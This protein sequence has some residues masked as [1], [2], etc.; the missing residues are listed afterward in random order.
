V[1]ALEGRGDYSSKNWFLLIGDSSPAGNITA[2]KWVVPSGAPMPLRA[3][4]ANTTIRIEIA[5]VYSDEHAA[6][7]TQVILQIFSIVDGKAVEAGSWASGDWHYEITTAA[8]KATYDYTFLDNVRPFYRAIGRD[9]KPGSEIFFVIAA[10]SKSPGEVGLAFRVLDKDPTPPT[11]VLPICLPAV[12]VCQ[13]ASASKD[14]ADFRKNVT[15]PPVLLPATGRGVGFSFPV[16]DEVKD[17][18]WL[19]EGWTPYAKI[20]RRLPTLQTAVTAWDLTIGYDFPSKGGWS[21]GGGG[22]GSDVA[23][24]T[25]SIES[26]VHGRKLTHQDTIPP[27]FSSYDYGYWI[28]GEGAGPS[29]ESW[30]LNVVGSGSYDYIYFVH[31]DFAATLTELIGYAEEPGSEVWPVGVPLEGAQRFRNL[32][33][34]D[35]WHGDPGF[36]WR[37]HLEG[38]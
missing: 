7:I 1:G 8:V 25:R 20:E 10:A 33:P 35:P 28:W 9:L 34:F 26:S 13:G 17:P 4:P 16:Y 27:Y 21:T 15:G 12:N 37:G 6:G 14:L 23:I 30:R 36:P 19:Y 38:E 22:Y 3:S 29:R 31:I 5:P 2:F 11:R 32:R 18:T 24:G